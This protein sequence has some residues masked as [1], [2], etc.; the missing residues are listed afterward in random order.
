MHIKPKRR[1][2]R[3]AEQLPATSAACGFRPPPRPTIRQKLGSGLAITATLAAGVGGG[4]AA[5]AHSAQNGSIQKVPAVGQAYD[6][7]DTHSFHG[8]SQVTLP[9]L[10]TDA[11]MFTVQAN[12]AIANVAVTAN[13]GLREM[14][15]QG[16]PKSVEAQL[17]A[18]INQALDG[19]AASLT[20]QLAI[21]EGDLVQN[22]QVNMALLSQRFNMLAAQG[23]DRGVSTLNQQLQ[24]SP[25]IVQKLKDLAKQVVI[26]PAMVQAFVDQLPIGE[27][28][29]ALSDQLNQLAKQAVITPAM[30][31]ALVDELLPTGELKTALSNQLNALAQKARVTPA[32]I[33]SF[34]DR[35]PKNLDTTEL[36]KKLNDLA[37]QAT[38]TPAMV[39][40]LV[41]ALPI[42]P[43]KD[44]ITHE[45]DLLASK[46][47]VT[48]AMI[49]SLMDQ[50]PV[51]AATAELTRQL[52][53]LA[54]GAV[55]SP[56][57]VQRVIDNLPKLAVPDAMVSS[58][59]QEVTRGTTDAAGALSKALA[60]TGSQ[61]T[62]VATQRINALVAQTKVSVDAAVAAFYVSLND[63]VMNELPKQLKVSDAVTKNLSNLV[64]D[65]V[66]AVMPAIAKANVAIGQTEQQVRHDARNIEGG[67]VGGILGAILSGTLLGVAYA[68]RNKR[69]WDE[70]YR[71]TLLSGD[72]GPDP[73]KAKPIEALTGE[74]SDW[75]SK[76]ELPQPVSVAPIAATPKAVAP[77]KESTP[78]APAKAAARKKAPRTPAPTTASL[79]AALAAAE[80][81]APVKRAAKS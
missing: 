6:L 38:V 45:L 69:R 30:V 2:S 36:Q 42:S 20:Q 7:L 43:A 28:K 19:T 21:G 80:K 76:V 3:S 25:E 52:D 17:I 54:K 59:K 56:Q 78:A 29:T 33:Q 57:M 16:L 48:P 24:P 18:S 4:A 23:I 77:R 34:I 70:E 35:L 44:A 15:K 79:A 51:D 62:S 13:D 75:K 68:Q 14:L 10:P 37:K 32:M 46:A 31:Q 40:A 61:A 66:A 73:D 53:N 81:K 71:P 26:T 64:N 65:Q 12:T 22:G 27:A 39:Q 60:S 41:D 1:P 11:R 74:K 8:A 67:I 58:L 9:R 63:W 50:L 49:H 47:T 55:I 5:V 72:P